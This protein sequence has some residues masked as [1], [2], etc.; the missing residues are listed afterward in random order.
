MKVR[1]EASTPTLISPSITLLP[2]TQRTRP[3]AAKYEKFMALVFTTRMSVR[4]CASSS[5]LADAW[6]NLRHLVALRGEG[7][8]HADAAEILVHDA[9][10]DREALLQG[11]PGGAQPELGHRGAPG[12]EGNEAQAEQPEHDIGAEQQI[13]ADADQDRQQDEADEAGGEEHAHAVDVEDAERDEVAGVDAV[14]EAKAQALQ[15]LVA[16]QAELVADLVADGLAVIVLQQ[17]EEAAQDADHEEDQGGGHERRAGAPV[18][19]GQHALGLVDRLSEQAGDGQ[20][21]RRGDEGRD[22]RDAHLPGMAKR[23]ARD[24]QERAEA[25]PPLGGGCVRDGFAPPRR[26]GNRIGGQGIGRTISRSTP[27]RR[28]GMRMELVEPPPL[29]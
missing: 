11:E 25:A 16:G 2:P 28:S 15:L 18:D 20:L 6:S 22:E 26:I 19:G 9:A 12:D 21:Q 4:S 17:R 23:H 24:A 3:I 7:A 27:R 14:V 10:D 1:N 8:D 13:G 29:L 5:A